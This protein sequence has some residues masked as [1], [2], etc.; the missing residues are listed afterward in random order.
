MIKYYYFFVAFAI[1]TSFKKL[2]LM[3]AYV[4]LMVE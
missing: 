1:N 4:I 2:I 3:V